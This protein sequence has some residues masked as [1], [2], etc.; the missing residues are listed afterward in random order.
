MYSRFLDSNGLVCAF[1]CQSV[2]NQ[3]VSFYMYL[4]SI[5]RLFY[6]PG[7]VDPFLNGI[8]KSVLNKLHA[9]NVNILNYAP[10]LV[11]NSAFSPLYD[12]F[13]LWNKYGVLITSNMCANVNIPTFFNCKLRVSKRYS[14]RPN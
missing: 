12:G 10:I 7:S 2:S 11:Y 1:I 3:L 4:E 6:M 5:Y 13:I 9:F 8:L 14:Q